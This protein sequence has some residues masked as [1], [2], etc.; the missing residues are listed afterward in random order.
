MELIIKTKNV[1]NKQFQQLCIDKPNI[2]NKILYNL[3]YYINLKVYFYYI[4]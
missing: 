2:I 4:Y 3:K 1:P